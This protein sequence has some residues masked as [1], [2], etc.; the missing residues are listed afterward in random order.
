MVDSPPRRRAEAVWLARLV[1]NSYSSSSTSTNGEGEERGGGREREL[2][3]GTKV[4]GFVSRN[5][6]EGRESPVGSDAGSGAVYDDDDRCGDDDDDDDDKNPLPLMFDIPVVISCDTPVVVAE[7]AG[8]VV[9]DDTAVDATIANG[10][11]SSS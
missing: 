5:H 9:P 2:R 7:V 8:A 6:S 3:K 11:S 4:S 10:S 1:S